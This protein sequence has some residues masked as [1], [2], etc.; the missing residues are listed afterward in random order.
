MCLDVLFNFALIP[1]PCSLVSDS[2]YCLLVNNLRSI[3]CSFL[4]A[5]V[6]K[7]PKEHPLTPQESPITPLLSFTSVDG[8]TGSF[9]FIQNDF[10]QEICGTHNPKRMEGDLKY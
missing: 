5:E 7:R 9:I 3:I 4:W 10:P 2:S 6:T 8:V 1:S